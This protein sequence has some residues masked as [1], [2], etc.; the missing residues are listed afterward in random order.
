MT[1]QEEKDLRAYSAFILKEYG[2]HI[3]PN[4]PVIPALYIIHREMQLNNQKIKRSPA[5]LTM[6]RSKYI[7]RSFSSITLASHGSI[8]WE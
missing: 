3:S 5:R 8:N 6:P 7:Q 4:D 1:A 2:F